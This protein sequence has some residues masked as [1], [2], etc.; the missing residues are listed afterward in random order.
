[1]N[2][3][4]FPGSGVAGDVQGLLSELA[5]MKQSFAEI[6]DDPSGAGT[7]EEALAYRK[8]QSE[9]Q[10]DR[11]DKMKETS[12]LIERKVASN[13][14]AADELG[15]ANQG[16]VG[17]L[18]AQKTGNEI[19]LLEIDLQRQAIL[20]D[21]ENMRATAQREARDEE[22]RQ[23]AKAQDCVFWSSPG[24]TPEVCK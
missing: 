8:L 2:L 14:V 15:A 23:L 11:L 22:D 6:Y 9:R 4:G 17:S 3:S 7:Y 18:Q 12:S 16:A 19:S 24:F 10:L 1:M 5:R 21:Q 13:S 20:L